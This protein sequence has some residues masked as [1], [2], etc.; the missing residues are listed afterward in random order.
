MT[1]LALV[2]ISRAIANPGAPIAVDMTVCGQAD[3]APCPDHA[4]ARGL[5]T[6]LGQPFGLPTFPQRLLRLS[7]R[8]PPVSS[9][10]AV[11]APRAWVVPSYWPAPGPI[12]VASATSRRG[13]E[14][15]YPVTV[16]GPIS[17]PW[18]DPLPGRR[19]SDA[20]AHRTAD[21]WAPRRA[22]RIYW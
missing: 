5:P 18:V 12:F 16:G 2:F 4:P 20:C 3:A 22:K 19:Q 13:T 7:V 8:G 9:S 11:T 6:D 10:P 14:W 17:W 1:R 21:H 15:S